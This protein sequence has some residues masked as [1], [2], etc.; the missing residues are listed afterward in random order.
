MYGRDRRSGRARLI[1][2]ARVRMDMFTKWHDE[3]FDANCVARAANR[4]CA[5]DAWKTGITR[6]YLM[7]ALCE[8]LGCEVN[9]EAQFQLVAT[10]IGFYRGAREA[11]GDVKIET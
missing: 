10:I 7:I 5:E 4:L 3:G 8:R 1:F 6:T 2:V 9:Q 11:I